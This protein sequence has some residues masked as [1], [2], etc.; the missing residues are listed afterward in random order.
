MSKT[1]D[2]LQLN[3]FKNTKH[4]VTDADGKR[5]TIRKIITVREGDGFVTRVYIVWSDRTA[6]NLVYPDQCRIIKV[7]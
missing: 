4:W 1:L 3:E 5:G 7:R 6:V 2:Q